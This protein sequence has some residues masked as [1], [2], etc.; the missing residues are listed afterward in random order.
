[1]TEDGVS[2]RSLFFIILVASLGYFVD[3]YDII[4]FSIVRV[5]SL[6]ELGLSGEI[7]R[8]K[9]EFI[10]NSQMAGLFIGSLVAGILGDKIGRMKVLFGSIML[11]SIA[12]FANG[13]VNDVNTYALIRFIAG[14]GLA[15][16]LGVGIT[17]VTETMKK[18]KR[19]YG[20]MI[21]ATIG[22]LGAAGAYFV[23]SWTT[24]RMAYMV[25]GGLGFLLLLMRVSVI[26][27]GMFERSKE[28]G[29]TMGS[30]R[31]LFA[32][33]E[34][35]LRYIYCLLLG[36]PV[37]LVLGIFATQSPELGIALGAVEPIVAGPI[38]VM[39]YVGMSVGD[40]LSSL[41]AQVIKSRKWAIFVFQILTIAGSVWFLTTTGHSQKQYNWMSFVMGI[42][43]G[44]WA[45]FITFTAEQFGTNLRSTVTTTTPNFAR[46]SLIPITFMFEYF[47]H[48]YGIA[49]AGVIMTL[50]TVGL[51]MFALIK[52]KPGFGK[53]LDFYEV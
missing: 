15:G 49:P 16:E 40:I 23:A 34:R 48:R 32:N 31:L 37:W 47:N 27:S 20:T 45:T 52:L 21:V 30:L 2:Q 41:L 14:L 28:D 17:L 1:M 44:Y 8:T 13:F 3:V 9:G 22:L 35:T 50:I 7:L 12:N 43:I 26:E 11:Y 25:G 6:T 4:I 38:I 18:G 51:S 42:G 36:I 5:E 19:G 10:L 46:G 53:D 24:W 29:V 33:K 39:A